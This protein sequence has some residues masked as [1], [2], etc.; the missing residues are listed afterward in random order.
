MLDLS[1]HVYVC[2]G[3]WVL[4]IQ[5]TFQITLNGDPD[6]VTSVPQVIGPVFSE[7]LSLHTFVLSFLFGLPRPC[8]YVFYFLM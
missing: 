5:Y 2:F 3:V 1:P 6:F 8:C 7:A 4:V